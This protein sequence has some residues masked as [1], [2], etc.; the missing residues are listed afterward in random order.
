MSVHIKRRSSA[1]PSHDLCEVVE[2]KGIG[3]P[4]TLA[5]GI[6]ELASIR[7][8][9]Y[10]LKHFGAVLHHN[11][12]K[13][14]I[15][16]GL[17][18]F[19]WI[20]G[21][22]VRPLKVIFGG[23]A[24]FSFG[25]SRIPVRD[26]VEA[27]AVEQMTHG[28]PGMQRVRLRFVHMTT[29]SSM[30]RHWFK[31][32]NKGDLPELSEPV[33]NDT[34]YVVASEPRTTCEILALAIEARLAKEEWSGSDIKV[35]ILRHGRA[36][37][38]ACNVP[39]LTGFFDSCKAYRERALLAKRDVFSIIQSIYDGPLVQF[40]LRPIDDISSATTSPEDCYVNVSGSAIDYGEDGMVGRGNGR[41]GLITPNQRSGNEA[42]FGKNPAYH[43]GKV[44]ALL[45]D[46]TAAELAKLGSCRIGLIY[47][48]GDAYHAPFE[49]QVDTESSLRAS[50]IS[51][52][53]MK[54][55]ATRGWI[56]ELVNSERYRVVRPIAYQALLT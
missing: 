2:R 13:V 49:C 39:C 18:R 44:G 35:M 1:L 6:A 36:L 41:H 15:F 16:G 38:V 43:V 45:A 21:R 10:C 32:R 26:I 42:L 46:R 25:S 48:R 54:T 52:I 56:E 22:Y 37:S 23:R 11:I 53:A 40:K 8:S 28:L 19:S 55:L 34:A 5:D 47:R 20:D 7:Y 33:S 12:D 51:E 3:H 4:D 27:A 9:Q 29:D 30:Y 24:S 14:A 31:P 50:E 17:A